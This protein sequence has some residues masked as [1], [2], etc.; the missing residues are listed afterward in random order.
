M[1]L[2]SLELIKGWSNGGVVL[3]LTFGA[4]WWRVDVEPLVVAAPMQVLELVLVL[5]VLDG[6]AAPV[7]V[8]KA[9]G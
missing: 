8:L 4:A 9:A 5:V 2:I 1:C 7:V 6:R 3:G